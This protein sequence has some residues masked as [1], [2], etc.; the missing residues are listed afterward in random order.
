VPSGCLI[1]PGDSASRLARHE[2]AQ[3]AFV[4]A[5]AIQ[6]KTL[7]AVQQGVVQHFEARE[8]GMQKQMWNGIIDRQ[9]Q[10]N[11]WQLRHPECAPGG[12]HPSSCGAAP[13]LQ[14]P[15]YVP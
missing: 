10:Q 14:T 12:S 1:D 6:G 11:V 2:A 9:M 5:L 8:M 13:M 7:P 4:E 3:Q 15:N